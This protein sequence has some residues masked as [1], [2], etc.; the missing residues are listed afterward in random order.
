[1]ASGLCPT[2]TNGIFCPTWSEWRCKKLE[3]RIYGYQRLTRCTFYNKRGKDFKEPRCQCN[4]CLQNEALLDE[5]EEETEN[6]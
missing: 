2:C 5:L 1:M 4:D 3:R 6:E